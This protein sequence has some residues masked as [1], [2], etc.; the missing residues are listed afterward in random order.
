MKGTFTANTYGGNGLEYIRDNIRINFATNGISSQCGIKLLYAFNIV[1]IVRHVSVGEK[2]ITK[3]LAQDF[4]DDL[5]I[6]FHT[7]GRKFAKVLVTARVASP[8]HALCIACED[9][10]YGTQVRNPN[11]SN[12]IRTFEL[13]I[14][15]AKEE[16]EEKE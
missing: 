9:W 3:E 7:E 13:D 2:D 11:S 10:Q 8:L 1:D 4:V 14:Y 6:Y 15:K 5:I 12:Y 16:N